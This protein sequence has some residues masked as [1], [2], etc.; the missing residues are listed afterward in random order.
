MLKSNLSDYSDAQIGVK[1]TITFP[2]NR[3][4]AAEKNINKEV[5]FKNC[6]PFTDCISE[7][8]TLKAIHKQIMLRTSMQ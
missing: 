8:S 5:V 1:V 7:I 3:T 6:A 4:A 2:N